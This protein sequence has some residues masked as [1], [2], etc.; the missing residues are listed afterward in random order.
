MH[1]AELARDTEARHGAQVKVSIEADA[2]RVIDGVTGDHLY[3][4]AQTAIAYALGSPGAAPL[5]IE[6]R[7][8]AD[9]IDLAIGAANG[10][11]SVP[12]DSSA[13][14]AIRHRARLLGAGVRF[15]RGSGGASTLRVTL[16]PA[17]G[18]GQG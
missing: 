18:A 11:L 7:L 3:R 9:G 1:L 16:Q 2:G 10:C 12:R 6:L 5:R 17:I 14:R 15:E 4:V 8:M 13:L